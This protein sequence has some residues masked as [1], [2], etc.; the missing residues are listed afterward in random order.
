MYFVL[1]LAV[2]LAHGALAAQYRCKHAIRLADWSHARNEM[3]AESYDV[4]D[5]NC[6]FDG[7]VSRVFAN[8]KTD[9]PSVIFFFFF[10]F[11]FSLFIFNFFFT[12]I[13]S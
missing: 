10:K 1:L 12:T 5:I 6:Y 9:E 8:F 2:C 3:Q 7:S 13:H 11:F 4:T